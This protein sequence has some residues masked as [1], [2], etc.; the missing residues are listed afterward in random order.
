MQNEDDAESYGEP[1]ANGQCGLLD[2]RV[3]E[4]VEDVERKALVGGLGVVDG[5]LG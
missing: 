5:D 2:D 3:C 4:R 1:S